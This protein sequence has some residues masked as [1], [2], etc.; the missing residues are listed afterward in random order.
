[1]LRKVSLGL[2][3]SLGVLAGCGSARLISRNG[4]GGVLEIQGDPGK[5]MEDA[6]RQMAGHCG[7]NNYQIVQEGEEPIGTDTFTQEDTESGTAVS[8][9]G[10]HARSGSSTTGT[11][12]TRTAMAWRVHYQCNGA[13]GGPPP[14]PPG[15]DPNQPPPP[16][17][18]PPGYPPPGY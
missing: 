12:S 17:G 11:T 14:G 8:R 7:P 15:G 10:R 16:P 4:G 9:N 3:I 13:A 18:P 5:G 6:H 1:M 2:V